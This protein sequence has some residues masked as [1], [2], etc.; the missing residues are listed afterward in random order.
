MWNIPKT[1]Q[2]LS[3]LQKKGAAKC[4]P[5]DKLWGGGGWPSCVS[6]TDKKRGS[7]VIVIGDHDNYVTLWN[8]DISWGG[9]AGMKNLLL[10]QPYNMSEC[11]VVLDTEQRGCLWYVQGIYICPLS[12]TT[13]WSQYHSGNLPSQLLHMYN[14]VEKKYLQLRQTVVKLELLLTSN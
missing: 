7:R 2:G 8:W 6:C 13:K 5:K 11:T 9:C 1:I 3:R 12:E 4:K 14:T 10:L